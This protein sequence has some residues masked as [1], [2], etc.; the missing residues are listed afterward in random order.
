MA[1][2]PEL[3]NIHNVGRFINLDELKQIELNIL[4]EFDA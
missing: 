4:K 1:W 2:S 3:E